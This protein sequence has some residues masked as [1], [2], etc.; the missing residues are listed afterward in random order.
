V[1]GR[2][3]RFS[4]AAIDHLKL[5]IDEHNAAWDGFFEDCGVETVRVIYEDLVEDYQ[6]TMLRLLGEIG[7]DIPEGFAME[8]PR[9]ERQAN[10]HSE[11][12][13]RRYQKLA[14][15]GH[16]DRERDR[17]AARTIRGA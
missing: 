11:E 14:C 8:N 4:F 2:D 7:I 12:W 10:E 13:V 15:Q 5:R 17:M 1:G 6:G 9:M 3:L 16:L